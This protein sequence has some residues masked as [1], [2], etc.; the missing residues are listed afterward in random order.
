MKCEVNV[1]LTLKQ[2]K[3]TSSQIKNS[4]KRQKNKDKS[5]QKLI[6]AL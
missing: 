3:K 4:G 2:Q 5:L 6:L 1:E